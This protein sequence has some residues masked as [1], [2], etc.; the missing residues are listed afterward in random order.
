MLNELAKECYENSKAH[1]FW[2][3]SQNVGE[4]FALM[5]SEISE[6]FEEHRAGQP[7]DKVYHS[8]PGFH[9][10]EGIPIELADCMIRI[11]D[12]CGAYGIDIEAAIKEKMEYNKT[13]P[14]MHNKV[15]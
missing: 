9:K 6:A 15:V 11:L 8:G 3:A 5:H 1:G 7:S 4:K 2:D 12:F 10:P 14:F 13:R